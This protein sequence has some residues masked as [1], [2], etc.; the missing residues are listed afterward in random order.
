[1]ESSGLIELD[2]TINVTC[3]TPAKPEGDLQLL[4]QS[5]FKRDVYIYSIVSAWARAFHH[6]KKL[7]KE[8]FATMNQLYCFLQEH[9]NW[10]L[11]LQARQ[12]VNFLG[13][14]ERVL[15]K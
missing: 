9:E 13:S 3:G 14:E 7:V 1:M 12:E 5:S 4:G 8:A 10:P 11:P 2:A 15:T 6:W